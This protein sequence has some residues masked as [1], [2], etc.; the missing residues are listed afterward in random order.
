MLMDL[1][2]GIEIGDVGPK[3]G[4]H[5]NDTGFLRLD[6]VRVPREHMLA[7]WQHVTPEGEYV[8]SERKT[9][10]KVHYATMVFAR[11]GMIKGAGGFL[12]RSVTIAMRYSC[13]RHQ[14]CHTLGRVCLFL[15]CWHRALALLIGVS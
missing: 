8:K 15:C 14:V 13:V 10:P 7:R 4:D 6:H 3:L 12:A 9:N 2:Q 5:A 11:G 1:F